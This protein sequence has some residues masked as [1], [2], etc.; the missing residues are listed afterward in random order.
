ML[1]I[2]FHFLIP[3]LS[4]KIWYKA[5]FLIL[6]WTDV[7]STWKFLK[8]EKVPN[9][10]SQEKNVAKA[11]KMVLNRQKKKQKTENKKLRKPLK[12][13]LKNEKNENNQLLKINKNT[14]NPYFFIFVSYFYLVVNKIILYQ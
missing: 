7:S 9:R 14:V 1:K 8:K 10:K 3:K 2:V 6:K 13:F 5:Y 11:K 4:I 12:M